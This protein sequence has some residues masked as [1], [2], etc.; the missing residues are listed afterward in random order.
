MKKLI[1]LPTYNEAKNISK[2][3]DIL[4]SLDIALDILVVDDN[5]PDGTAD[6][7]KNNYQDSVIVK[8]RPKKDGLGSAYV[9]A[10]DWALENS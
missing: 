6:L 5:S 4:L 8:V 2:T 3:I 9:F 1:I 10:F 7:V